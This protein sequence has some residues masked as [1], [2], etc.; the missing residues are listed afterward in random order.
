MDTSCMR[1]DLR[2]GHCEFSD[3]VTQQHIC[4]GTRRNEGLY[5]A[6][7]SLKDSPSTS[8]NTA[9]TFKQTTPEQLW[10]ARLGNVNQTSLRRI[11]SDEGYNANPHAKPS[12]MDC[13]DCTEARGTR[14]RREQPL[15]RRDDTPASCVFMNLCGPMQSPSWG[16]ARYLILVIDGATR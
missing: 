12:T 8:I 9:V 4:S 13:D 7:A 6:R 10:H 11:L 14:G 2:N 3:V 16:G 15:V 1:L 5:W